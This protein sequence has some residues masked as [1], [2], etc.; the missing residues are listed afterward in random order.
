MEQ[1]Y[2]TVG[3]EGEFEIPAAIREALAI[4]DGM[5]VGIRVE[6]GQLILTPDMPTSQKIAVEE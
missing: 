6:G 4:V 1:F 5:R 3:S 2:V